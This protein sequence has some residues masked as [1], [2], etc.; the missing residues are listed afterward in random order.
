MKYYYS[1]NPVRL[2]LSKKVRTAAIKKSVAAE[3][4]IPVVRTTW[5]RH[6][7]EEVVN[8]SILNLLC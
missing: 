7:D 8:F 2:R 4:A 5:K 3:N 1:L 6:M